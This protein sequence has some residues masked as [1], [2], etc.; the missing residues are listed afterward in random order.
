MDRCSLLCFSRTRCRHNLEHI[1]T[2]KDFLNRLKGI[3][4][5]LQLAT[6]S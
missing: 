1:G 2:N 4:I 6:A 5:P 3:V